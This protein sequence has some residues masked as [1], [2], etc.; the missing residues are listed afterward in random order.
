M[1]SATATRP[2][3]GSGR[4]PSAGRRTRS[5]AAVVALAAA[6]TAAWAIANQEPDPVPTTHKVVYEVTGPGGK[7]PL[8]RFATEGVNSTEQA[9]TVDLPW[10]R[11]VVLPAGPGLVVA[12]VMAT[13][14]EGESISCT[15]TID[16][17][18]VSNNTA[19]GEHSAV[20]C[21]NMITPELGGR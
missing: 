4:K 7:A 1:T 6:G 19:K 5:I 8:I 20:S 3:R 11:E 12:Q 13:N 15:I 10:R 9:E 21:S 2:D 17:H 18:L 16:G 14:G